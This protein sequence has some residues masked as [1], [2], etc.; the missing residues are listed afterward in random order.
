MLIYH[1]IQAEAVVSLISSP[2]MSAPKPCEVVFSSDVRNMME[3][4]DRTALVLDSAD[5]LGAN[6][7]RA[8]RWLRAMRKILIEQ[9]KWKDDPNQD[10]RMIFSLEVNSTW[11]AS[12]GLPPGPKLQLT[13]PLHATSFFTPERRVQ[14]QMVFHSDIFESVR[15]ICPP[16]N[17]MLNLMQCLMTGLVTV[18][19]EERLPDG[20]YRTT[21]AL[22]PITWVTQ[23][24]TE[25]VEIFGVRDYKTLRS[26]C[27]DT[28]RAF[29]LEIIKQ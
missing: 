7:A 3:W 10:R 15:K 4:G 28:K 19:F 2:V 21:R 24:E 8:H 22:P 20:L 6:W 27:A 18:V 17:D 26:A 9:Y 23:H 16:I 13:L 11:R 29:K 14:W 1:F 12:F 25:L 5:R